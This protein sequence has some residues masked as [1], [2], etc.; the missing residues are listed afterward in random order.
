MRTEWILPSVPA[1]TTF[2]AAATPLPWR[3]CV[4]TV[5]MR[6]Y[7]RAAWIIHL[8]SSMKTVMGF[9]T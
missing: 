4:P 3:R 1:S 9:S 5:T 2:F 6:L 7:F 8:P